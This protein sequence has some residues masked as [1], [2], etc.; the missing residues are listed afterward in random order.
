MTNDEFKDILS[1][2]KI[3]QSKYSRLLGVTRNTVYY[4]TTGRQSVAGAAEKLAMLLRDRPELVQVLEK[5][6]QK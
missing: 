1:D 2:L 6:N 5:Y 4:W 3:S